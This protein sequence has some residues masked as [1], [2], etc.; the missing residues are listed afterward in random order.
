M[1][2]KRLYERLTLKDKVT[3]LKLLEDPDL[4]MNTIAQRMD[5]PQATIS[6]INAKYKIWTGSSKN[7][8]PYRE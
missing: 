5:V 7:G 8:I 2:K 3:I 4:T 1:A 6:A